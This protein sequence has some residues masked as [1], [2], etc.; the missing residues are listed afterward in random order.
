MFDESAVCIQIPAI[1]KA[2]EQDGRRLVEVEASN[3]AVDAEGD[4]VLQQALLNSADSFV[5]SGHLDID[6]L[7]EIGDRLGLQNPTA[8][9]VGNPTEVKDLGDGR[10]GVVGELHKAGRA[11]ADE[12][13]ESLKADPPIRW[14]ASIYGFPMP[15]QLVDCRVTKA[16][17]TF[18][19]TRFLVKGLD[20][21]SLAFTRHPINTAIKGNAR[22]VTAKSFMAIMKSR[23]IGGGSLSSVW[24]ELPEIPDFILP[25]RSKEEMLGH[26]NYHIKAGKCPCIGKS[27][28]LSVEGFSRHFEMCCGL[29]SKE[30]NHHG[31][32]LAQLLKSKGVESHMNILA[33]IAEAIGKAAA[34]ESQMEDVRHIPDLWNDNDEHKNPSRS[35]IGTGPAESMR[36]GGLEPMINRH[37]SPA[38]Q[39]GL[40]A[41]YESFCNIM[42][43]YSKAV[44]ARFE[45]Q[46]QC[47]TTLASALADLQK[48]F[49]AIGEL[50]KAESTK[51]D[52]E[53]T[54]L[55]KAE[56]KVAK[57]RKAFRKAEMDED[58][59]ER[60]ER[61]AELTAILD[62]LKSAMKL[63]AK[64]SDEDEDDERT[65]KALAASKSLKD[66]VTKALAEIT[67]AE[68]EEKKEEEE[69]AEKAKA[70]E[71]AAK[72]AEDETEKEE[73]KDDT[74]KADGSQLEASKAKA[75]ED[76]VQG[77]G[78]QMA[79]IQDM[80]KAV[81][82]QS[83]SPVPPTFIK[84][85]Q[86]VIDIG[87]RIR[88]AADNG[89]LDQGAT[90]Q[91]K[92]LHQRLQLAEQGR[93]PREDVERQIA[94]APTS[95]RQ[96]FQAA[97]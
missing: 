89:Q 75:L 43:D 17:N 3:Q 37:S 20:W 16:E 36:S 39:T 88:E 56:S 92:T 94:A 34:A 13:W 21:R 74:A 61:K 5:K 86:N 78:L 42:R 9:I 30:A 97:A 73:K 82:G 65:E 71:A 72:K 28:R 45:K 95:I 81:M 60:E 76:A 26:F 90:I 2:K 49:A 44:E 67:K 79:T 77:M 12:L 57:A 22:I 31:W 7:S 35:E 40:T 55:G 52:A 25:P 53:E 41:Q 54:F 66:R 32:R 64:A 11:K 48:S 10:T 14:Q 83:K 80:L 23:G 29:P 33:K 38:A 93:L 24:A 27:Q 85:G 6:H 84:G 63:L 96:I 51:Q 87:A 68:D 50:V 18:G 59:K 1:V 58:E 4:V 15:G 19:A 91:A 62:M 46:E 8:Y 70:A 69:K 47:L